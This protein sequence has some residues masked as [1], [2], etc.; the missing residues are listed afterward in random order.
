MLLL[1][2][3]ASTPGRGLVFIMISP[4]FTSTLFSSIRGTISAAPAIATKSRYCNGKSLF[5]ILSATALGKFECDTCAGK[6]LKRIMQFGLKDQALQE[7]MVFRLSAD[8]DRK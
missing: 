2:I 6:I 5:P 8:D 7:R 1:S 4:S 3:K